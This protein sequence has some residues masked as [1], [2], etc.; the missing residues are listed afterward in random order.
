MSAEPSLS[1]SDAG[2]RR[3]DG[4]RC[5]LLLPL[6]PRASAATVTCTGG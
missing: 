6:K 1:R 4:A 3:P 2:A 5:V